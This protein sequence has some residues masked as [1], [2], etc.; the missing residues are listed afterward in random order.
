MNPKDLDAKAMAPFT[1]DE[2]E[3]GEKEVKKGANFMSYQEM[4]DSD[5]Y[6]KSQP[7]KEWTY[8][9]EVQGCPDCP[10]EKKVITATKR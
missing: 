8:W 3:G 5:L 2:K 6:K 9:E 4:I 7:G 10:K 1:K